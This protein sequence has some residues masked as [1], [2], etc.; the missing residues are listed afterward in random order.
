M[1]SHTTITKKGMTVYSA[2][3]FPKYVPIYAISCYFFSKSYSVFLLLDDD[4][5]G[6]LA[7]VGEGLYDDVDA[8]LETT[9][10]DTF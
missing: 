1:S 8:L 4:L 6:L 9:Y 3:P 2:M 5:G 7:T 10:L